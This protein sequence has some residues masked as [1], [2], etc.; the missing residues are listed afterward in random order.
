MKIQYKQAIEGIV[1][2]WVDVESYN[3][4]IE[5]DVFF[6]QNWHFEPVMLNIC[7]YFINIDKIIGCI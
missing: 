1:K 7:Y 6:E 4:A 2:F 3:L 5:L